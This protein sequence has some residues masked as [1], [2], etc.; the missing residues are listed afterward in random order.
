MPIAELQLQVDEATVRRIIDR[1]SRPAAFAMAGAAGVLCVDREDRV[2]LVHPTY[3]RYWDLPGGVIEPGES[4]RAA[5]RREWREEL[6]CGVLPLGDLL[7]VDYMPAMD[8]RPPSMRY[9]FGCRWNPPG[10]GW[11]FTCDGPE[12]DGFRWCSFHEQQKLQE[13]APIL[14]RRVAAARAAMHG[15]RT[16]YL[17]S[18]QE[19]T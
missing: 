3:K 15:G 6:G 2:L 19:P 12:I 1:A 4:P 18:G 16:V 13:H 8:G 9:V 10:N 7:V 5:A 14:S 17:E 11:P